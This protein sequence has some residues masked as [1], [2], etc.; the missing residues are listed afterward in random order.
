MSQNPDIEL[1]QLKEKSVNPTIINDN[2]LVNDLDVYDEDF[3]PDFGFLTRETSTIHH[4]FQNQN[5]SR[6]T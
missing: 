4:V 6:V 1:S 2:L 3:E 5:Q